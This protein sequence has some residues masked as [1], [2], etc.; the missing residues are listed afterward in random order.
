[1][2][3]IRWYTN[4]DTHSYGHGDSN[5]Y[6]NAVTDATSNTYTKNSSNTEGSTHA[7]AAPVAYV[8]EKETHYSV[9]FLSSAGFAGS[10][11]VR[12]CGLFDVKRSAAFLPSR[13]AGQSFSKNA[14][15]R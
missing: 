14:H 8:D 12:G 11:C 9:G 10:A 7:P 2:R 6:A 15:V 3:A 13:S 4:A 5:S 1:L